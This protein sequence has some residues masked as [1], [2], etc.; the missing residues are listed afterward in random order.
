MF[1]W[2]FPTI[3]EVPGVL[4]F[5]VA[6]VLVVAVVALVRAVARQPFFGGPNASEM[7]DRYAHGKMSFEEYEDLKGKKRHGLAH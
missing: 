4:W 5:L 6:I 3:A 7:E 2:Q 1:G